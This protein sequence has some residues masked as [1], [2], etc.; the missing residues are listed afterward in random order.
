MK[1][2]TK[3]E[4]DVGRRLERRRYARISFALIVANSII[5]TSVLLLSSD[6]QVVAE[7]LATAAPLITGMLGVFTAV[8]LG[9]LGVSAAE[10]IW[11][12]SEQLTEQQRRNLRAAELRAE[13]RRRRSGSEDDDEP[14]VTG[15]A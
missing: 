6:R 11:H 1:Q 8:I 5:I 15:Y 12:P 9:Y 7:A 2:I 14:P 10:R 3:H 13:R 4:L